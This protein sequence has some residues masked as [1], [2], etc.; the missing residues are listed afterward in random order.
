MAG[1]GVGANL[2]NYGSRGRSP[3]LA[4]YG[5]DQEAEAT[6]ELGVAATEETK[7]KAANTMAEAEAKQGNAAL[8]SSL[9]GLAGGA[10]LGS[11]IGPW[12]TVIGAVVG[13]LAGSLFS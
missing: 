6:K 1:F 12:G 2:S 11:S 10:A 8:G 7:R 5:M 9:G 4:A 3:S 13:G